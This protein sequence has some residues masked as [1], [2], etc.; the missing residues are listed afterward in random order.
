MDLP[1]GSAA[2]KKTEKAEKERRRA[3]SRSKRQSASTAPPKLEQ[4]KCSDDYVRQKLREFVDKGLYI[5]IELAISRM[6]VYRLAAGDPTTLVMSI[7]NDCEKYDSKQKLIKHFLSSTCTGL[8]LGLRA[9]RIIVEAAMGLKACDHRSGEPYPHL[10]SPKLVKEA[11]QA[12][13]CWLEWATNI[14]RNPET[15]SADPMML[16]R[17]AVDFLPCKVVKKQNSLQ[18]GSRAYTDPTVMSHVELVVKVYSELLSHEG[19]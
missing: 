12:R 5:D 2:Q 15:A 1:R 11:V 3:R 18:Q 6:N 10:D 4:S 9:V 8:P 7:V 17:G 19:R 13:F 16:K 14:A